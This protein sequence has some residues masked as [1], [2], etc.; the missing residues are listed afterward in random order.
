MHNVSAT[1]PA[2]S[3]LNIWMIAVLIWHGTL[4]VASVLLGFIVLLTAPEISMSGI[5]I[6]FSSTFIRLLGFVLAIAFGGVQLWY[7]PGL[8]TYQSPARVM[9]LMVNFFGFLAMLFLTF[10]QMT[11]QG[12]RICPADSAIFSPDRF[13]MWWPFLIALVAF[14][15]MLYGMWRKDVSDLYNE[16]QRLRTTL[17]AYLY[18]S[19][20]LLTAS[21]FTFGLLFYAFVL[22]FTDFSNEQLYAGEAPVW[23]GVDNYRASVQNEEFQISLSNVLW[24]SLI[25][26]SFQTTIALGLALMMNAKFA[27]RRIFR[28]LFYAPSV[29][30]SVVISLIFLWLFNGRGIINYVVYEVFQ[31]TEPLGNL[32]LRTPNTNWLNTPTRLGDLIYLKPFINGGWSWLLAIPLLV[33]AL[34]M[35]MRIMLWLRENVVNRRVMLYAGEMAAGVGIVFAIIFGLFSA[36]YTDAVSSD[37]AIKMLVVSFG[38]GLGGGLVSNAMKLEED[39][40]IA[41]RSAVLGVLTAT[42]LIGVVALLWMFITAFDA[43]TPEGEA[44]VSIYTLLLLPVLLGTMTTALTAKLSHS[45]FMPKRQGMTNPGQSQPGDD[46]SIVFNRWATLISPRIVGM[47]VI[48]CILVIIIAGATAGIAKP[49]DLNDEQ[50]GPL[51]LR[52]PSVALMIIM[53][54]N[55]FTTSPTFMIMF[56]AALQDVPVSLYEAARVDGANR[57]HQF[58]KITLPMLRPVTLL[59]VVLGT[60]GT[61]QIFDQVHVMT[62]GGPSNTT[63]TPTYL[64]FTK[65]IGDQRPVD[66]GT[67]SAMAFIL[68]AIIFFFTFLQRRY[69]ERGTEQY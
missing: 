11:C 12:G 47:L 16:S 36:N 42:V 15:T 38:L 61:L 4:G 9:S 41:T 35:G 7:W 44:H 25:V 67:S 51:F 17:T 20:Y 66:I 54:L 10:R 8:R 28:T 55:I 5:V 63:L 34:A 3:H 69:I 58:W 65:A 24:Y 32:G 49:T 13:E 21:V 48:W 53:L 68:G 64:I 39:A 22:G 52:G 40:D 43:L 2:T 45:R 14:S 62:S 37:V 26:V 6:D 1:P 31:L 19:P 56:L 50:F 30:S 29:T 18:I 46:R 27:A 33:I 57:W 23:V 60:I 59:I